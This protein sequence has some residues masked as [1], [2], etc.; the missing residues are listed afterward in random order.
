MGVGEL[1]PGNRV[2][3][4]NYVASVTAVH[5]FAKDYASPQRDATAELKTDDEARGYRCGLTRRSPA[6]GAVRL[7]VLTIHTAGR[8]VAL[9]L[10]FVLVFVSRCRITALPDVVE[11]ALATVNELFVMF[12]TT[13]CPRPDV[14]CCQRR[15]RQLTGFNPSSESWGRRLSERFDVTSPRGYL[16]ASNLGDLEMENDAD[17]SYEISKP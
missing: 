3:H 6:G 2:G 4:P 16:S 8:L 11:S 13:T 5:S 12:S 15:Q 1:V 14:G 9:R 10:T 7:P 17:V